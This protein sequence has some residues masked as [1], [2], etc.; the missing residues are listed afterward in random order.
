[1]IW[2]AKDQALAALNI[3]SRFL[4]DNHGASLT[5]K[6]VLAQPLHAQGNLESAKELIEFLTNAHE[7]K[8]GLGHDITT[9]HALYLMLVYLEKNKYGK[10]ERLVLRVLTARRS[11]ILTNATISYLQSFLN[12]FHAQLYQLLLAFQVFFVTRL[13][14][15]LLV[16]SL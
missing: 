11:L 7:K 1:L 16:V 13:Y 3:Q 6:W 15:W 5:A 10:A 12:V 9:A 8:L 14:S 2:L 4:E